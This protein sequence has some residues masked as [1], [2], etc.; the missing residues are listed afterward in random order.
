MSLRP[1][2][3]RSTPSL[4][5]QSSPRR[6]SPS[7]YTAHRSETPSN[8]WQRRNGHASINASPARSTFSLA[9]TVNLFQAAPAPSTTTTPGKVPP[10]PLYY[11]YTEDFDIDEYHQPEVLEPPPQFRIDKTIPEDRPL[12]S[13]WA[14]LDGPRLG[15]QKPGFRTSL[16]NSATSTSV[17]QKSLAP[18][19]D[20]SVNDYSTNIFR[21]I[22]GSP[23]Q[24]AGAP[25]AYSSEEVVHQKD[26]KIIRLSALGLG[27][28]ELNSHVEKA[29]GLASPPSFE[30][31]VSDNVAEQRKLSNKDVCHEENELETQ[32]VKTSSQSLSTHLGQFPPPPSNLDGQCSEDHDEVVNLGS[33]P[34]W[35][36]STSMPLGRQ[37]YFSEPI[38]HVETP[39]LVIPISGQPLVSDAAKNLLPRSSSLHWDRKTL[40]PAPAADAGFS[41]LDELVKK[42]HDTNRTKKLGEKRP[43]QDAAKALPATPSSH[44]NGPPFAD[45]TSSQRFEP[46]SSS[47]NQMGCEIGPKRLLDDGLKRDHQRHNARRLETMTFPIESEN[48]I[49][50]FSHQFPT[51]FISC[52]ESPMLAPKPISPARQLKLKNSI[53]QLMKALPPLPP[54]SSIIAVSPP[55]QL[56]FSEE[57]LPCR[58]S[59]L[60]P[61]TGATPLQQ[62][63]QPAKLHNKQEIGRRT[64]V[65]KAQEPA[66][67]DSVPVNVIVIEQTEKERKAPTPPPP[68]LKLKMKSASTLRPTSPP[69]SH[70]WNSEESYPWSTQA[71]SVWSTIGDPGRQRSISKN[72]EI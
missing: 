54:D 13:N 50:N 64:S 46:P 5:S 42:F 58:F 59:A 19:Q 66:E 38:S 36:E 22:Q 41:E 45:T 35:G 37:D 21:P 3:N 47:F 18:S 57:E 23:S 63:P 56:T 26:R 40:N 25:E 14:S 11:D 68:K 65:G 52:S 4:L 62:P 39:G 2:A 15:G 9:S 17:V 32:A 69:E 61:E 31:L 71:F 67:L 1:E 10:S 48:S 44:P 16:C 24:G 6:R 49:P 8:D 60:I 43:V 53:P 27:A 51:K 70:P 34:L 30:V 20:S 33:A 72:T 29:F 55:V 7:P 12:S 28:R